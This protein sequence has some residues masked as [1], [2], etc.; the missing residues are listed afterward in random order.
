[1][2]TELPILDFIFETRAIIK[3]N[4]CGVDYMSRSKQL[5]D[6]TEIPR[7]LEIKENMVLARQHLED[8]YMRL[9]KAVEHYHN[10]RIAYTDED[11]KAGKKI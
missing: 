8:A 11:M 2:P 3:K 9:G 5:D 6:P 4:V 7:I 10:G 1:M